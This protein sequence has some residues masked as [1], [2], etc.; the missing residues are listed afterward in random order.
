MESAKRKRGE[1]G[2]V[3][4]RR[5]VTDAEVEEFYAILGRIRDASRRL[6]TAPSPDAVRSGAVGGGARWSPAFAWEDFAV[7]D[8]ATSPLKITAAA[9][10]SGAG[11]SAEPRR[12]D[13][14]ADPEPEV[15]TPSQ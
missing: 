14:N 9:A 12:I 2:A 15:G 13:L 10:A 7:R 3:S 1:D 5:E 6:P 11:E 4:G 8:D